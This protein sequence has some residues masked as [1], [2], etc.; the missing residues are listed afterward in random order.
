MRLIN[1]VILC[2][3]GFCLL[4][5]AQEGLQKVR[6]TA[7]PLVDASNAPVQPIA[8]DQNQWETQHRTYQH[9]LPAYEKEQEKA[10]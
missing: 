9:E 10:E 3:V 6:K 2:L 8:Y 7:N 5:C 1:F 4:G